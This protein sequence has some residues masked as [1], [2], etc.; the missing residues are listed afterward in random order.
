MPILPIIRDDNGNPLF[1]RGCEVVTKRYT[2]VDT[3]GQPI[4]LGIDVKEVV[5]HIEGD[6]EVARFTGTVSGSDQVRITQDGVTL[7]PL[8]VIKEAGEPIVTVA[9][10]SGSIDLS[11]IGWR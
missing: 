9:S 3:S 7:E 2:G 10:P 5:I 6:I 1:G 11:V 8:P 4:A